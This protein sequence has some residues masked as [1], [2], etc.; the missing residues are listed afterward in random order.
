MSLDAETRAS[1]VSG[2]REWIG[3]P[4]VDQG[5]LKGAGCDCVGLVIGVREEVLGIPP[6]SNIPPY[7]R[8][9]REHLPY[10]DG[11]LHYVAPYVLRKPIPTRLPG[12]VL[13]FRMRPRGPA[14]HAGI[15]TGADTIVHAYSGHGVREDPLT[16]WWLERAICALEFVV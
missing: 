4:Y 8:S 14:K 7:S 5:R 10:D 2:A 15:V 16:A 6:P 1:L 11:L 9:W 12:D 13:I 3:T